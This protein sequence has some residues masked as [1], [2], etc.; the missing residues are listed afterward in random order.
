MSATTATPQTSQGHYRLPWLSHAFQQKVKEHGYKKTLVEVIDVFH[1]DNYALEAAFAA[2]L[3]HPA[4][5]SAPKKV[6][7]AVEEAD[8]R[9]LKV[10]IRWMINSIC[11]DTDLR[12]L[13]WRSSDKA[14]CFVI[15]KLHRLQLDEQPK[16]SETSESTASSSQPSVEQQSRFSAERRKERKEERGISRSARRRGTNLRSKRK[17]TAKH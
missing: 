9:A 13:T 3:K 12:G 1:D 16:S 2:V 6:R 5:K 7:K 11:K 4:T 8:E 14:W 17:Q 10:V 15:R